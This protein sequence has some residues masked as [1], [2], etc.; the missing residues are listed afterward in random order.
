MSDEPAAWQP[1]AT[2]A[3][4]RMRAAMLACIRQF[5]AARDVLEVETPTIVG[6]PV[7]EPQLTNVSCRLAGHPGQ[8]FYLRTSPEYHLKRLLA[9]GAPDVFEIGKVFRDGEC[10]ARHLPEFTMVEWYRRGMRL[11]DIVA[12]TCEL[13]RQAAKAAG[14]HAP[15]PRVFRYQQLFETHAGLDP[16]SASTPQVI[17]TARTLLGER[18]DAGLARQLSDDREAWLDLLMVECIEPALRPLGLVVVERYPAAQAALARLDP[19]DPRVAER[20]EVYLHGVELANGYCELTDAAEQR[21]RFAADQ[22]LRRRRGLAQTARDEHFLAALDA[23]LPDCSGVA[24]GFD[25]LLMTGLGL[26][27]ITAAVSFPVPDPE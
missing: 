11:P 6:W 20:F 24:L 8:P 26:P 15:P 13:V 7:S 4:L 14:A 2:I 17:N 27:G 10:G 18:I 22:A 1:T 23:G 12:E 3:T 16:L 9:A 21:R 19:D 5:F 25:R